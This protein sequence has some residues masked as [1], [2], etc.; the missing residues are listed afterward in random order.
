MNRFFIV[1]VFLFFY[2]GVFYPLNTFACRYTIREIG[3]SDIGSVPYNL[4]IFTKSDMPESEISTIKKLS[5]TLLDETNVKFEIINVDKNE[6]SYA[7]KY[8][9]LFK[10]KYFP[11]AVFV[12][13][14]GESLYCPFISPERSF[15]ESAWLLFENLVYSSFRKSIVNKL[16]Q[17]YCIVL[18]VEGKNKSENKYVIN[19]VNEAVKEITA[20]L[21]YMPKVVDHPPGILVIP[22]KN[23]PEEQVLL[24][25]LGIGE[26]EVREPAVAIIYGR[27]RIMGPV[28]KGEQ[29]TKRRVFNLLTVVGADCECGLDHSWILGRMIPLRW[30]P[31]V[32]SQLAQFL[33]FDVE[34]PL[35]KSE[36]SQILSVKPI[37]ENPL[38]PVEDNLLG[39][40]ERKLEIRKSS[41]NIPRISASDIRKSF[42]QTTSGNNQASRIIFLSFGGIFFI[43]LILGVFIF[44]KHKK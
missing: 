37:P 22:Y 43:V 17:A 23:T 30:E 10:I 33:G 39:Y 20:K 44:I 4:Y 34:N 35:V 36:M 16:L 19:E 6:S 5:K 14:Q 42:S 27:G 38:D 3:F 26:E 9:D 2:T 13:P 11:S 24:I 29:I 1:F 40:A 15:N 12:S 8:L 32:Q 28:L 21:D 31:S 25:S 18:V 7:I 41:Q